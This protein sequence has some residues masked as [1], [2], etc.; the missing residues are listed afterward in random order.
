MTASTTWK[1]GPLAE[2]SGLTV[3]TLHHWDTIG[4]LSPSRRT[5]GGHREY[6]EDDIVRLYQVLALRG[7]GLGLESIAVC[8]DSGVDP[9]RVLRDH[10]ASVEEALAGLDALRERLVRI[11]DEVAAGRAPTTEAVLAALRATGAA[12]PAAERVLRRHLDDEQM[13]TL[14]DHAAALGPTAHYLLEVEWPALYRRAEA[15]RTAGT[16]PT[17]APVR[18]LVA[19]MDEL[20]ALFSGGDTTISTG[21]RT[22]W[23]TDP[24][25]LSGEAT[26]RPGQWDNLADYLDAARKGEGA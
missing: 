18:K 23:R 15:L 10:R 14:G 22:A 13:R 5:P 1:V 3:R 12:G 25:A 6:T 19:R 21:V 26:A 24:A 16:P 11:E 2:A 9:T 20:S 7:L 8:L 4:L 17:A